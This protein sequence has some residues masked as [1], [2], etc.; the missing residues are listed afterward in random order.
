MQSSDKHQVPG[1]LY[2]FGQLFAR[3]QGLWRGLSNLES[4]F[5]RKRIN[6]TAIDRPLY[7][8]GVARS[9]STII[10]EM[11][12]RHPALT[13]HHYSDY[14]PVWFPYWWNA[15]RAKLPLP[16]TEPVER[17]HKDRL[18]V[19][20]DSPEAVEEVLWMSFFEDAHN[21]ITSDVLSE[22]TDNSSFEAFYRDHIRKLVLTRN[23][24]RYLTKG[25]YNTTRLAY[26]LK[27]FPDARFIV[28]VRNPVNHVASLVKQ[29]RLFIEGEQ[30]NPRVG[31]HLRASG[32][33]EFGVGKQP[34]NCADDEL[35]GRIAQCFEAGDLVHGWALQWRATYGLVLE[36]VKA[37]PE[38]EKA[39]LFVRFEDLC[40]DSEAVIDAI[41]GHAALRADV[42]AEE[43]SEFAERLA[44]PTYYRPDFSDSEMA[45]LRE[46]VAPVAS[47]L[48]YDL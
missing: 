25:N 39:V 4:R 27:L 22:H 8:G 46:A 13:S 42:F 16:K 11:L 40:R 31:R 9:G 35:T 21:P 10:T 29:D 20:P 1:G 48:G 30:G 36:Q 3:A 6:A 2:F 23:R 26:I 7:V 28:P 15:L 18:M 47:Q 38:M 14:P 12:A 5:L 41:L 33:Y 24:Q 44:E 43:R 19:T 32:H 37:S 45:A 34:V 17:S